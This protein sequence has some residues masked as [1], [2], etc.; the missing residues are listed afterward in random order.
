MVKQSTRVA[1]LRNGRHSFHPDIGLKR[2]CAYYTVWLGTDS[3]GLR[4]E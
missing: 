3:S 2:C 4:S 1:P